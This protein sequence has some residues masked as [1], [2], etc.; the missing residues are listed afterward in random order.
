MH[1][2]LVVVVLVV[3][4]VRGIADGDPQQRVVEALHLILYSIKIIDM[5]DC[6]QASI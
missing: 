4:L 5:Y 1:S 3:V 2:C 6:F